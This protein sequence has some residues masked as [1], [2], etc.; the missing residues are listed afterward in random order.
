MNRIA[1]AL[2]FSY[3]LS[4]AQ[5]ANLAGEWEFTLL[6]FDGAQRDYTRVNLEASGDKLT[7]STSRMLKLEGTVHGT[8]IEFRALDK[9]GK[10]RGTLTGRAANGE[11]SGEGSFEGGKDR[12]KWI[13]HRPLKPPAGGPRTVQ[14][15]PE[16]FHNYF[17]PKIEPVLHIFPGDTVET[18]SVDAG[19][20][21]EKGVRRSPGGN[22][23]T[24]PF[25][26]EGA[27][28][29]DTLVVRI[30][31]LRLNRDSAGSGDSIV[32]TALNTYYFKDLKFAEDFSSEWKLD[33]ERGVA[34]L[35][36]P[37]DRLKNFQVK[38]KPMLGCIGVAPPQE[39]VYRSGSLGAWGGNMDY[40]QFSE[41]VTLYLPVFQ[42]GALLFIGDGHAAQGDGELTGDALE[43]STEYSVT[44]DLVR[45]KRPPAP[46]S[47]NAEYRMA[48]GIA[49]SLTE[50]LQEATSSL[51]RWLIDDFK[52]NPNE[53]AIVLGT[54]IRYDVAEVVD[55]EIHVVA[56]IQKSVLAMLQ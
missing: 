20:T 22:P 18:K 49:H 28:P 31:R 8:T 19:G 21:D 52:L 14:F 30:N 15:V 41:G 13:A 35:A 1:L 37:T 4:W 29:G 34:T 17:S 45:N 7:G 11:L 10:E 9:D 24:G 36:K 5:P 3:A 38:L 43:T 56:K 26:V 51:A 47:E 32:G 33:R 50:A 23:L 46:R 6:R 54:S 53:V 40:N 2:V 39:Q 16:K 25:Y 48:S 44:V 42:P 27:L 12:F 55:P